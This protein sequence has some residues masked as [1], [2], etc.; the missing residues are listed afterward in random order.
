MNRDT[1]TE[2]QLAMLYVSIG[3]KV[4]SARLVL[5]LALLLTFGLFA[6]SMAQPTYERIACA[7]LFALLIFLPA[8]R[9]D[10]SQNR[11]R[12]VVSPSKE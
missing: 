3:L 1:N 8:C 4:L 6:W 9:I 7:T 10:A 12:A 5:L 11:D 2:T